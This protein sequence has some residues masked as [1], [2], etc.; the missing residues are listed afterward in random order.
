MR[1]KV[2]FFDKKAEEPVEKFGFKSRKCPPQNK[3]FDK[4]E[5]EVLLMIKNIQFR[6]VNDN[7]LNT[8]KE[9]S[10]LIRIQKR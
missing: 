10:Q 6:K 5:D 3:E 4:F 7:L 9:D 2:F 8:L 1:W